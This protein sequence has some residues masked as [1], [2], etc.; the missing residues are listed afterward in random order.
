MKAPS[1]LFLAAFFIFLPFARSQDNAAKIQA[2][3]ENPKNDIQQKKITREEAEA[4]ELQYAGGGVGTAVNYIA[5]ATM[6]LEPGWVPGYVVLKDKT[7]VEGLLLRY[8]IYHQQMQFVRDDDTM[9]FASPNEL[10]YMFIGN[11][12]FVYCDYD[13]EGENNKGYFEVLYDG[14]TSLYYHR[15]VEYH[16]EN[17]DKP[18]KQGDIY[19]QKCGY[20]VKRNGETAIRILPNRKSILSVLGDKEKEVAMFMDDN[21]LKGKTG[22]ELRQILAFYNNLP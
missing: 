22:D 1:L 8:D 12:K 21:D 6:Y 18:D 9:A 5:A 11:H 16:F 15:C 4:R 10:A 7:M 3:R 13:C 17:E 2:P 20:F 14:E 19:V